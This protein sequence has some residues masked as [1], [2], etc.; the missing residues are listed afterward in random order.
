MGVILEID[1]ENITD[2]SHESFGSDGFFFG[3]SVT[4][5]TITP[6][7]FIDLA[8]GCTS[9]RSF[10]VT[11]EGKHGD[12]A[13][14]LIETDD[15][16]GVGELSAVVGAIALVA[17]HIIAAGA[18]SKNISA[19]VGVSLERFVGGFDESDEI[20]DVALTTSDFSDNV[21]TPEDEPSDAADEN[22]NDD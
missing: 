19:A 17:V 8:S 12:V 10:E 6:V 5:A 2:F 1:A 4:R 22:E 21:I 14:V 13:G 3:G 16:D 20:K 7:D 15:H 11:R 9:R 18:K